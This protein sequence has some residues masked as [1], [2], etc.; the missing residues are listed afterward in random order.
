MAILAEDGEE[1]CLLEQARRKAFSLRTA[2]QETTPSSLSVRRSDGGRSLPRRSSRGVLLALNGC[3]SGQDGGQV[4]RLCAL[5]LRSVLGNGSEP[6]SILQMPA[7]PRFPWERSR[8][9]HMEVA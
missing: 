7:K 9:L 5:W 2:A 6:G 1:H 3:D 8:L 4:G